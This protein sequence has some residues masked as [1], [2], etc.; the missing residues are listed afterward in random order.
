MNAV[1]DHAALR[2]EQR[3]GIP[4]ETLA[5]LWTGARQANKQ[6]MTGFRVIEKAGRE[7]RVTVYRRRRTL[8]VRSLRGV[9]ITVICL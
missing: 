8:I 1:S 2:A 7:Y 3:L 6:D 4:G 9:F 5:C